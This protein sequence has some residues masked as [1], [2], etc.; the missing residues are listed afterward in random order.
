MRQCGFCQRVGRADV[1]APLLVEVGERR[2]LE[3]LRPEDPR[4][5]DEHVERAE[6]VDRRVHDRARRVIRGLLQSE[7]MVAEKCLGVVLNKVDLKRLTRYQ[8]NMGASYYGYYRH[9]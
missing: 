4:R 2:L 9:Q 8:E 1:D 5:V 3:R 6:G 7:W